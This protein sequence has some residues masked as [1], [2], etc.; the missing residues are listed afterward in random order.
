MTGLRAAPPM[1][2]IQGMS[3]V[4]GRRESAAKIEK[5]EKALEAEKLEELAKV[6]RAI[7]NEAGN[8]A[9]QARVGSGWVKGPPAKT[10]GSDRIE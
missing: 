9:Q 1:T 4:G 8:A 5:R 7:A 10:D 2:D 6:E 3:K